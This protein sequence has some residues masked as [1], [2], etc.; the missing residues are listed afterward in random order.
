MKMKSI[1][2]ITLVLIAC[3]AVAITACSDNH[4]PSNSVTTPSQ[5][6]ESVREANEPFEL[7]GIPDSIYLVK[8]R[9]ERTIY[10]GTNEY[11]EIMELLRSIFPERLKE[12]SLAITWADESGFNCDMMRE[13]FDFLQLLY[14]S[15]QT[16][17]L[18]CMN[19]DDYSLDEITFE[20]MVFPLSEKTG[21]VCIDTHNTSGFVG[22]TYGPIDGSPDIIANLL[23]YVD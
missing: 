9:N 5:S 7:I 22:R 10:P 16:V 12:A 8:S 1:K 23:E 3:V 18:N 19:S 14:D 15:A 6:P 21:V 13:E 11:S 4:E 20:M 17:K 2:S